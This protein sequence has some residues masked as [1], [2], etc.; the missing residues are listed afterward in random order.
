MLKGSVHLCPWLLDALT[1]ASDLHIM[2]TLL[3]IAPH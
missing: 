3:L 1:Q 2:W